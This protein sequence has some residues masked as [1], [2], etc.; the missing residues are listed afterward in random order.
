[1]IDMTNSGADGAIIDMTANEV[2]P[3]LSLR[4]VTKSYGDGAGLSLIH[5]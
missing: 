2:R 5:I 1:M 3:V 4:N